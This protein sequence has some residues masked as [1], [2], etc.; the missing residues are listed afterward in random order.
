MPRG[1]IR[2]TAAI[3][4]LTTASVTAQTP[5][6]VATAPIRAVA[7][8]TQLHDVMIKPASDA[9]FNVARRAPADAGDWEALRRSAI[10][11]AETGNLLM[12]GSRARDRGRWMKLSRDLI[13]VS[14]RAATA[15]SARDLDLL[16]TTAD[17][18]VEVCESCHVRYRKQTNTPLK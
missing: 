3:A 1:L 2:A 10:T 17:S 8:I 4:L 11:L 14:A 6:Q 5:P 7:T 16:L 9:I 18:L 13:D 12:L 15:A